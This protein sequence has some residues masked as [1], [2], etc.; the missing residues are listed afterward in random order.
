MA[1]VSGKG[2][3]DQVLLIEPSQVYKLFVF[4]FLFKAA[5]LMKSNGKFQYEVHNLVYQLAVDLISK[6]QWTLEMGKI[7][8]EFLT[9]VGG[10]TS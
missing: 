10:I 5:Q 7:F 8:N 2:V 6:E 4:I 1:L 3:L 9:E